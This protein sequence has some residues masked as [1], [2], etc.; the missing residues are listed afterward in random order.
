MRENIS[1]ALCLMQV[2]F[3]LRDVL[4]AEIEASGNPVNMV[5]WLNKATLDIIGLAGSF[6][7][8]YGSLI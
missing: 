3:Q 2:Y 7:S 5:K 8:A 4:M 6:S 1:G